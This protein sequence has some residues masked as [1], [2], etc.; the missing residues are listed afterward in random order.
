VKSS[1]L[2]RLN[3]KNLRIS[4]PD[5]QNAPAQ[6]HSAGVFSISNSAMGDMDQ[7]SQKPG[8]AMMAVP[9]QMS[10][11]SGKIDYHVHPPKLEI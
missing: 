11:N 4:Q 5:K 9:T 8:F 2:N 3:L 7:N 1:R 6:S 10:P